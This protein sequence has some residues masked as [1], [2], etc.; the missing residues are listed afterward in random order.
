MQLPILVKGQC[1]N[2]AE[3]NYLSDPEKWTVGLF[4]NPGSSVPKKS[5]GNF[6]KWGE[7]QRKTLSEEI[8][9]IK[10]WTIKNE[11]YEN[12]DDIKATWFVDPPYENAGKY[13]VNNKIDYDFLGNWCK[14]RN[15]QTI[16][17]E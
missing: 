13:Y 2:D 6:C 9:K 14:E 12:C 16:V 5:P 17:C 11:S 10:H 15:G 1:L 8:Y 3:Y 7:G 4:L